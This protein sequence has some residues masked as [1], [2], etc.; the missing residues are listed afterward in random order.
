MERTEKDSRITKF[1]GENLEEVLRHY[2]RPAPQEE[3]ETDCSRV[4]SRLEF[5]AVELVQ[6]ELITD[7]SPASPF[8]WPRL[9]VLSAAHA[10]W[11]LGLV[12]VIAAAIV[13]AVFLRMPG[14]PAVLEDAA[15]SRKIAFGEVVRSGGVPAG[16][17]VLADSSRLE[18]RT[19]SEL[20]LERADDGVRIHLSKGSVL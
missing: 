6:R 13:V 15:G 14:S 16:T 5:R 11:R 12:A 2:L 3:V 17:L 8:I 10:G 9:A 18:I 19:N 7:D 1:D 4:Q 20:L